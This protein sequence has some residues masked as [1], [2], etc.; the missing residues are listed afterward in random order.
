MYTF[1]NWKFSEEF[2]YATNFLLEDKL[3]IEN[4]EILTDCWENIEH[5]IPLYCKTIV[6]YIVS[7]LVLKAHNI[8]PCI[9]DVV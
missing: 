3:K 7:S 5:S 9:S 1:F 6:V 8:V 4:A 2:K